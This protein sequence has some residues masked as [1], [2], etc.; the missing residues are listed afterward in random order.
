MNRPPVVPRISLLHH[1]WEHTIMNKWKP[2][3]MLIFSRFVCLWG[4]QLLWIPGENVFLA[5]MVLREWAMSNWLEIRAKEKKKY[6][7]CQL[8]ARKCKMFSDYSV[9]RTPTQIPSLMKP[10][11]THQLKSQ[12]VL[13]LIYNVL[14]SAVEFW[15]NKT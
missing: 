14:Q 13:S 1:Y 6:V 10:S 2:Q 12:H 4:G 15:G 9:Y 5:F 8:I 7:K 11:L 3:E